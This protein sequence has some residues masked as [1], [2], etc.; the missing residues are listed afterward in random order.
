MTDKQLT[1]SVP[2]KGAYGFCDNVKKVASRKDAVPTIRR[3]MRITMKQ[4]IFLFA[5]MVFG[6]AQTFGI[7]YGWYKAT[8][9]S[10]PR[11]L[12]DYLQGG[13]IMI[14][15]RGGEPFRL[16][17]KSAPEFNLDKNQSPKAEI[18]KSKK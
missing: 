15:Y 16:T 18:V 11:A 6:A 8:Q 4:I 10:S 9:A 2:L 12:I 14:E 5:G 13:D 3:A 7:C 17:L 1:F